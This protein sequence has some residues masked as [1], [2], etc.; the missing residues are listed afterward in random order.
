MKRSTGTSSNGIKG[1]YVQ[2]VPQRNI[3][4][5]LYLDRQTVSYV[6]QKLTVDK[7]YKKLVLPLKEI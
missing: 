1:I 5:G 2:L 3:W 6:C 7:K 4:W